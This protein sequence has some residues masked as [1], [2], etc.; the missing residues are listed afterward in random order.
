MHLL[1]G[2]WY[3]VV[4]A[5]AARP[6]MGG[7]GQP[8]LF[9]AHNSRSGHLQSRAL[10]CQY[11][12]PAGLCMASQRC[13]PAI[14]DS[15][16]AERPPTTAAAASAETL[17]PFPPAGLSGRMPPHSAEATC[18]QRREREHLTEQHLHISARRVCE[19]P[20]P[21]QSSAKRDFGSKNI[22]PLADT[23]ACVEEPPARLSEP[24]S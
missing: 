24:P 13:I 21:A 12:V 20:A 23:S 19:S 6:T 1:A 14:D 18:W 9:A 16:L 17:V 4:H 7:H 11:A 10:L 3:G 5:R 2:S 8:G 15:E 22:A